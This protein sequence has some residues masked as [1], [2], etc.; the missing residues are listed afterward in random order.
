M[1]YCDA[2]TAYAEHCE[3]EPTF[4]AEATIFYSGQHPALEVEEGE[5]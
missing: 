2:I 4:P 3:V 5:A 1:A